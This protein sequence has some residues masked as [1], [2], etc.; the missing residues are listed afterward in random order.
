VTYQH[1]NALINETSPY[2][3]QHAHN[4]VNWYPWGEAALKLSREQ[5]KPIFL[6]IGYAACH[7]CHVMEHESFENEEVAAILNEHY[8]SIKVDREERPDLDEIYMNATVM[9]TRGHGGWPMSVWLTPEGKPFY[10]G[11]YF[12]PDD[13]YQRP[14]FK[15]VLRQLAQLWKD[16]EREIVDDADKVVELLG[17]LGGPQA[18]NLTTEDTEVTEGTEAQ[19]QEKL[20]EGALR[21]L[22]LDGVIQ[23]AAQVARA[24]DARHGGHAS[25]SNKFP[26]SMAIELILRA[27]PH[28]EELRKSPALDLVILTLDRMARGGIYDHLGGGIAR[29]STDVQWLVPH[30]EKMLYDQ[31]LVSAAYLD[32]YQKTA[33][34][35]FAA[36]AGGI[37]D[38]VL[39]D[40]QHPEGGFYSS[41]DAD[42]EGKEG[43]FY[44]WTWDQL[45]DALGEQ[46]GRLF[47]KAYDVTATGN[48]EH[49]G[50]AH[51]PEGP[52]N[53]LRLLKPME[54]TARQLG[55]DLAELERR[56]AE[57][58]AKLL[59][60]RNQRV[61]PGLDDKILTAWNGLMI[62]SLAR[63]CA[64]LGEAK[65]LIAAERAA[66]F[67]LKNMQTE[68]NGEKRL[69]RSH[70]AGKSQLMAYADDYA[71]FIDA[72]TTLYEIT[73]NL[74]WLAEAERLTD[75]AMA[76]YWDR[77]QGGLFFT[78]DDHEQLI[79]RSK[80]AT[81]N[82]IPSANSVMAMNLMRLRLLLGR[83]E[84][85]RSAA[86][87]LSLF[88]NQ[89]A[90]QPFAHERL[91][92]GLEM[93]HSTMN[94]GPNG[95][96]E[97]A[98][99]GPADG[100][101]EAARTHEL[102]RV[103]HGTYLPNKVMALLDPRWPN[104]EKVAG[105]VPLLAGKTMVNGA[106]TA[107][108]C[109]NYACQA[110]VNHA[111]ALVRQLANAS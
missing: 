73:G 68:V 16:R 3:L 65:Y 88:S 106:P 40:L 90:Q 6:S 95:F 13:Y 27:L 29:Y 7:W 53:I 24:M 109:R 67:I 62:A 23:A 31:A 87:I 102:I 50:D 86:E 84:L 66:D 2:L 36:T 74:H 22:S 104:A 94:D 110:P 108:V 43:K 83:N 48:W 17:K 54:E 100:A 28:S 107:Y 20:P 49:P 55:I 61:R 45:I 60:V 58:R 19:A 44:I 51:V 98:I 78:A 30:F 101:P 46:E 81:D 15:G 71:F 37:C 75:I 25:G 72:L 103:V 34:A 32:G 69:L 39:R 10:G 111:S 47:A 70:R 97:I 11:T 92:S 38:Y 82:A 63:A 77:E 33:R 79:V 105:A 5:N 8:I 85:H 9:F 93:F 21:L 59:E 89:A 56:L 57:A 99:V 1:T 91:L 76:H 26:P 96:L 64:V 42:S 80:L 14:G 35:D 41:E 4:P 52:K 12:P 18:G